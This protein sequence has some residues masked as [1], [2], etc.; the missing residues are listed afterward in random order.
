M[1]DVEV[2][3]VSAADEDGWQKL[4]DGYRAFY[5]TVVPPEITAVTWRR[6]LEPDGPVEGLVAERDG[7]LVGFVNYVLHPSTWGTAETC[8]LEDL[9]VSPAARA[10]ALYDSFA[11]AD[12][13]VRY[14]VRL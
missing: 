1:S 12:D 5:E 10:R 9:F 13:F 14:V 8:Y 4:W 3:A 2:R 7:E 11:R 6:L